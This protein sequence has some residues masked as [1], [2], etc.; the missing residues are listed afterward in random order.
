M[1]SNNIVNFQ[2]SMTILNA[3]TKKSLE[4]YH[5]HLVGV[6]QSSIRIYESQSEIWFA[7]SLSLQTIFTISITDYLLTCCEK[8]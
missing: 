3:R 6:V 7:F 4:T 1:Y 8:I 5:M 2:E